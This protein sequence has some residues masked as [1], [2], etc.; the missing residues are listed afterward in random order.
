MRTRSI[1]VLSKN[2]KN[3]TNFQLKSFDFLNLKNLCILH[4]QFFVMLFETD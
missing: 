4:G 3:I 2:K 1:Y